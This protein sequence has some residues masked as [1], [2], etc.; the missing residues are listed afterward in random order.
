M[1][2][3]N[4]ITWSIADPITALR[5]NDF[6]EDLD[7]IY[8]NGDDRGRIQEAV[9]ATAL[10]IDIAA[11]SYRVWNISGL[12][13]GG[14]DISVTD[15]ATN[16]VEIDDTGT[17]QINTTG[18]T[19]ANARLWKVTAS[20]GTITAIE[21][22]KP[23]VIGG[24]I[25]W[26]EW[27]LVGSQEWSAETT[28]KTISVTGGNNKV[29]KVELKSTLWSANQ[30]LIYMT[31][32]WLTTWYNYKYINW[33]SIS[34]ATNQSSILILRSYQ[35]WKDKNNT[36]I[37]VPGRSESDETLN[38]NILSFSQN[39]YQILWASKYWTGDLTEF[40]FYTNLN[41]SGIINVYEK[42]L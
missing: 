1:P 29:F 3:K 21:I 24:Q 34:S 28:N 7:D 6:N 33:S 27:T 32:N 5:L 26:G 9:S 41:W 14:T 13:A 10:K 38:F 16:Y 12:Y 20:G 35:F 18:W 25:W 30:W 22:W 39:W 37:Y 42:T 23:D 8:V 40:W 36:T 31:I 19:D 15:A 11:F 4:S 2:R 17:I